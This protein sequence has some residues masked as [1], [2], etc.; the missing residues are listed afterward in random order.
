[1]FT[2]TILSLAL[3]F[4]CHIPKHAARLSHYAPLEIRTFTH[5]CP[6]RLS[7]TITAYLQNNWTLNGETRFVTDID[8][9][10]QSIRRIQLHEEP[11]LIPHSFHIEAHQTPSEFNR[12][13]QSFDKKNFTIYT[14]LIPTTHDYAFSYTSLESQ[15]SN[16]FPIP[17]T[18]LQLVA[19][20]NYN[21]DS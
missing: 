4:G 20:P 12:R 1:M 13:I 7:Q 19:L 11:T 10:S 5:P 2:K 6:T 17:G 15:Y 14:M 16:T 9:F 3:G 8:H 21:K 18:N